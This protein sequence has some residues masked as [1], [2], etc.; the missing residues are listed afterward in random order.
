MAPLNLGNG[1]SPLSFQAN[2]PQNGSD[3]V[4]GCLRLWV[5]LCLPVEIRR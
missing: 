5:Y 4:Y 1:D 2:T 3:H